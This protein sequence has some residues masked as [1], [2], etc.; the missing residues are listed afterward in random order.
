MAL[1]SSGMLS[2]KPLRGLRTARNSEL[3]GLNDQ[4]RHNMIMC[5]QRYISTIPIENLCYISGLRYYAMD[6]FSSSRQLA[7]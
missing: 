2:F 3:A 4:R 6:H 7:G 5:I 1:F